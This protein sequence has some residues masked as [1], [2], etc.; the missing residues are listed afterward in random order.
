MAAVRV[1]QDQVVVALPEGEEEGQRKVRLE[2]VHDEH[3]AL[4]LGNVGDD[5]FLEP[6]DHHVAFH[7]A[8]VRRRVVVCGR[9][10][11]CEKRC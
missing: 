5:A 11:A 3:D 1:P 6:R 2:A 7:A 8:H 9:N 10:L 4:T